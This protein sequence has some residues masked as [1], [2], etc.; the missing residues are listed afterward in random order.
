MFTFKTINVIL[1]LML[2]AR[3]GRRQTPSANNAN[4]IVRSHI[5]IL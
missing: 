1:V 2:H 3:A 5:I 4:A